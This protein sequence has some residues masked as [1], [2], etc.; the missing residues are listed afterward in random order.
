MKGGPVMVAFYSPGLLV[1]DGRPVRVRGMADQIARLLAEARGQVVRW[2]QLEE[3]VCA[4]NFWD[5]DDAHQTDVRQM[6]RVH[7]ARMRQAAGARPGKDLFDDGALFETIP[8]VG[9]R[10]HV[11]DTCPGCGR[12][13]DMKGE[14]T[15]RYDVEPDAE[16]VKSF[17]YLRQLVK[18][19]ELAMVPD[20]ARVVIT[21]DGKAGAC[22]FPPGETAQ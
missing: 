14:K 21:E 22:W 7:I 13:I 16:D 8:R 9:I 19:M 2:Q 3:L 12:G 10:M 4:S 15:V 11:A 1:V 6:V 5:W 18:A 17:G 20:T